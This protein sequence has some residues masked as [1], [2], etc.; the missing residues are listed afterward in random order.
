MPLWTPGED[1]KLDDLILASSDKDGRILDWDF[2]FSEM[3]ERTEASI[4][5]RVSVKKNKTKLIESLSSSKRG[6][7]IQYDSD[8]KILIDWMFEL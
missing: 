1:K 2:I 4:R 5:M 7:K 8:S 6:Q 3:P